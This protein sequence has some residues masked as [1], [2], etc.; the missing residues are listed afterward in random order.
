MATM[1]SDRTPDASQPI[2]RATAPAIK[3]AVAF[4]QGQVAFPSNSPPATAS[5]W[6]VKKIMDELSGPKAAY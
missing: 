5:G 4:P 6:S 2:E 3:P 1:N